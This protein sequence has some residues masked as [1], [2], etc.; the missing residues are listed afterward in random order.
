MSRPPLDRTPGLVGPFGSWEAAAHG[1][2]QPG[3]RRPGRR[4][5]GWP[6]D[7][8]GRLNGAA[9]LEVVVAAD[10]VDLASGLLWSAGVGAVAEHPE[11]DG[12]VRL[13]TDVPPGGRTAVHEALRTAGG[14]WTV[15]EVTVDDGLDAWR[16]HAPV[17]PVGDRLLIRPPWV[18]LPDGPDEAAGG[19]APDGR[20]VLEIDPGR[21]FGHGAH[22]TTVLCL[23]AVER[24]LGDGPPGGGLPRGRSGDAAV[25]GTGPVGGGVTGNGVVGPGAEAVVR[26]A[27]VGCGSGVIAVAAARLGAGEVIAVD[28]DPAAVDAAAGNARH[29]AVDDVVAVHLAADP[30]APLADP[31]APLTADPDALA[32]PGRFDLV[33]ANIGAATLVSLADH[34]RAAAR[35]P[36]VLSGTLDPPPAEVVAAYGGPSVVEVVARDG[37]TVLVV[38]PGSPPGQ[39]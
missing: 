12:R 1:P 3:D 30:D 38:A 6:R 18:P 33:V 36:L 8:G 20:I 37:W 29:N 15:E 34:L 7:P 2:R 24:L 10:E 14:R 35:G 13:R 39:A 27:D 25:V 23:E 16:E 31:R 4:R 21:A 32:D 19:F 9:A 17:V 11:P 28:V 22:P 5:R 26:V